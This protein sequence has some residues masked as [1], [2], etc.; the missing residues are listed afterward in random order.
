MRKN[1]LTFS[2]MVALLC[3]VAGLVLACGPAADKLG[4]GAEC[5]SNDQCNK[6]DNQSCLTQFKGGYCGSE[7][8]TKSDDCPTGA[9][10]VTHEGKNY[11]FRSCTDKAECNANRSAANESNCSANITTPDGTK[12]AKA[13]IP[14]S[15]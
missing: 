6:D 13:C 15:G 2:R 3:F 14:P 12:N 9:L 1:V 8:C 11:C 4:I 10:C 5:T 7:G